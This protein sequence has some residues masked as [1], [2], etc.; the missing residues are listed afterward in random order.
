MARRHE[1]GSEVEQNRGVPEKER[2]GTSEGLLLTLSNNYLYKLSNSPSTTQIRL[3]KKITEMIAMARFPVAEQRLLMKQICMK[4]SA[5]N[6]IK[7]VRCR[8]CRSKDLRVK[9][10]EKRGGK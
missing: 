7:G 5:R 6:P 9:A 8:R 4:C 10:K 2:R 1:Q 3:G